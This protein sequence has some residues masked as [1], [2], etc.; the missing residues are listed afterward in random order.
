MA[1]I[2]MLSSICSIIKQTPQQFDGYKEYVATGDLQNSEII[3]STK[4]TYQ[5]RPSRADC[6]VKSGDVLFAK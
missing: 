2:L 5:N 1:E 6:T 3:S 4:V